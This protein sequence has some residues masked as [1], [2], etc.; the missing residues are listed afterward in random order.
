MKA[1]HTYNSPMH[2]DDSE[3]DTIIHLDSKTYQKIFEIKYPHQFQL[4]RRARKDAFNHVM[5]NELLFH[6]N[7]QEK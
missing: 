2:A 5:I 1:L 7:T 6:I 4:K 3:K